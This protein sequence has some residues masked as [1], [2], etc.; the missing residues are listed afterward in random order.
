MLADEKPAAENRFNQKP[1]L[2]VG[3]RFSTQRIVSK[4]PF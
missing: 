4:R 2:E 1:L 3:N